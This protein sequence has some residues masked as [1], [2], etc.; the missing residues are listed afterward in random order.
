MNKKIHGF[1]CLC[2]YPPVLIIRKIYPKNEEQFWGFENNF[3]QIFIMLICCFF[4]QKVFGNFENLQK[5][6]KKRIYKYGLKIEF[7][8]ARKFAKKCDVI[9]QKMVKISVQTLIWKKNWII[10]YHF[11]KI[12][13]NNLIL[14]GINIPKCEEKI[15]VMKL[16]G[17]V[18]LIICSVKM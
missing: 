10:S 18:F 5:N 8:S 6:Y 1:I 2:C 11:S 4:R 15:N 13:W 3:L 16:H 14:Y 7:F 9:S 12:L 17:S